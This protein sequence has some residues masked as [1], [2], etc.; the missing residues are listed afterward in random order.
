MEKAGIAPRVMI[1]CSHANSLKDYTRQSL[2]CRDV[3]AQVAAGN[4]NIIGIMIESNLVAGTQKL[5]PDQPLVYGQS[6]TDACI[7]WSET[8]KLLGELAA[9]VRTRR[10][11]HE[12]VNA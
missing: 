5:V 7:D 4:R 12:A 6:I 11:V 1:D 8:L 3:A 10:A 2:V 9:S